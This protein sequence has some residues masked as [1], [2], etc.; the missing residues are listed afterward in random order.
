M[1]EIHDYEAGLRDGRI[2]AIE[3]MQIHQNNR[4]NHHDM[5]LSS[6]ERIT[7]IAVGMVLLVQVLLPL[8]G[9]TLGATK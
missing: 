7:Y 1:A 5:R 3:K 4:L 9:I 6:L 8:L 2:E